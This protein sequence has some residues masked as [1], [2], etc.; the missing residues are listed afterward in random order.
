[1]LSA[2]RRR[3]VRTINLAGALAMA[4]ATA[5]NQLIAQTAS[6]K[7][8]HGLPGRAIESAASLAV[9]WFASKVE[10]PKECQKYHNWLQEWR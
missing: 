10:T 5:L 8:I 6:T 7:F 4:T 9:L 2:A 3:K 1:M